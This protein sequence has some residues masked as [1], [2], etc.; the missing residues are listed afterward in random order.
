MRQGS[1]GR[2]VTDKIYGLQGS[3]S[4]DCFRREFG[5]GKGSL[6]E[7]R[8]VDGPICGKDSLCD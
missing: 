1:V 2:P 5:C 6:V 3:H 4:G 8:L 7:T